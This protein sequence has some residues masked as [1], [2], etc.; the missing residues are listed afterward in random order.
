MVAGNMGSVGE[1]FAM[2]HAKP[3]QHGARIAFYAALVL[4][5]GVYLVANAKAAE[6]PLAS[7]AQPKPAEVLGAV[8]QAVPPMGQVVYQDWKKACE[9][10]PDKSNKLCFGFQKVSYRDTKAQLLQAVVGY[11]RTDERLQPT[12]IITTPLGAFL[13]AGLELRVAKKKPIRADFQYCFSNGCQAAIR[14]DMAKLDLLKQADS[15]EVV[16]L[17]AGRQ[18][19]SVPMSLKG[20]AAVLD[21]LKPSPAP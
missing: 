12:L 6:P 7:A 10:T 9:P 1:G 20:L 21:A 11:F 4:G 5:V 14:L 3:A 2:A 15:V 13:L 19:I 17:D 18:R 8:P 16:F